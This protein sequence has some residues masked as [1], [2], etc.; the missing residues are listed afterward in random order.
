MR[1]ATVAIAAVLALAIAAGAAEEWLSARPDY[2]WSFPRDH[3]ARPGYRTEWWYLTGHLATDATP[4]SR[5]GYQFTLFRV[6]VTPRALPLASEWAVTNLVMGHA[7]VSDLG[8]RRHVF[9][10]VLYRAMPLL[11]GFG[12][13]PDP[14][15]AWSRAPAGTD[16]RWTL[17]W[18]GEA[19]DLGMADS[20]RGIA[21]RLATRPLKPLVFQGP[22]GY[23]RK[24]AG[25][26]SQAGHSSRRVAQDR[27]R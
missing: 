17:D 10:E 20:S 7:A 27:L 3:W 22:N 8:A 5:F 6:G 19:F 16:G 21:L 11:G 23:S 2:S 25:G 9:S 14:R 26:A 1:R 13:E 4:A 24:G 15:L 12:A 18:N